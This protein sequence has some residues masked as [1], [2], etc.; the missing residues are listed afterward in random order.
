MPTLQMERCGSSAALKRAEPL[1][2]N[3]KM[4][5]LLKRMEDR[6]EFLRDAARYPALACLAVVGIALGRRREGAPGDWPCLESPSC[7]G[8]GQLGGCT[9]PAALAL[10]EKGRS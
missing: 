8:C 7:R 6:R 5:A 10:K 4:N 9:R 2:S 1:P 3:K